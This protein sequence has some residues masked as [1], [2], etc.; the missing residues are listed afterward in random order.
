[1][2]RILEFDSIIEE[3]IDA[4]VDLSTIKTCVVAETTNE[5]GLKIHHLFLNDKFIKEQ[6]L[7]DLS[8]ITFYKTF[9][10]FDSQESFETYIWCASP[11]PEFNQEFEDLCQIVR[12]NDDRLDPFDWQL[13][14]DNML[15]NSTFN[16]AIFHL[17]DNHEFL[18]YFRKSLTFEEE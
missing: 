6:N 13:D 16:E 3:L 7:A 11:K 5:D 8:Q 1:M 2:K 9:D 18:L 15:T 14:E 17:E 12:D 4:G 10:E